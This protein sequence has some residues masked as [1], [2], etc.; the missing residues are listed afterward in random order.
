VA[1]IARELILAGTDPS[2][3]K[4]WGDNSL[5]IANSVRYCGPKHPIAEYVRSM[6]KPAQQ[7]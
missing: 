7:S 1:Q 4:K 5:D 3:T 6:V 2:M